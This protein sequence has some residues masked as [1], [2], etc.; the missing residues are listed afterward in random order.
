VTYWDRPEKQAEAVQDGWSAPGDIFVHR[1]DGRFEYKSRRDDLIITS[2]YNV[3]GPEVEDVLQEREEVYEAAV[4]GVPDE[5]RGT[6]VKAVVVPADGA[7]PGEALTTS[8]QEYVK[9]S[10]APYK[11][12]R[13]IEYVDELP[14]TETGKIRREK[15]RQEEQPPA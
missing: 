5:E 3:P 4:I 13:E 14:K 7:D 12:P 15:L 10:I 6:I 9:D 11:Y 2:G 8:L 1:E